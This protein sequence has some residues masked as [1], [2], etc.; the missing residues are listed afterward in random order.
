[1]DHVTWNGG[2]VGIVGYDINACYFKSSS[3]H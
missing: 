3:G 1:V 2:V